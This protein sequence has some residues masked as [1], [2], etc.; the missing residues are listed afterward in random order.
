VSKEL[1]GEHELGP[2]V[3]VEE[4]VFVEQEVDHA[5]ED[6]DVLGR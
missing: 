3:S 1:A 5:A 6:L 4:A 2:W